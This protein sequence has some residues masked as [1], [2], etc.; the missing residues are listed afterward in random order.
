MIT[1]Q[2]SDCLT[3]IRNG[4]IAKKDTIYI[5]YSKIKTSIIQIL[6]E[7]GFIVNYK[8]EIKKNQ[9]SILV[10]LKYIYPKKQS[11]IKYIKR[12]SK[13]SFRKYSSSKN[14]PRVLNGLGI[15]IISTSKGIITDKLARTNKIGGEIICYVY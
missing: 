6:F 1:D 5:P 12:I 15:A 14:L 10:E 8:L 4:C 7:Q 11:V 2:I 3:R 13:P 9:K